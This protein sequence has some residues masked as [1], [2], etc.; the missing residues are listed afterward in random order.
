MRVGGR[1]SYIALVHEFH[2]FVPSDISKQKAHRVAQLHAQ[3]ELHDPPSISALR[4]GQVP[5]FANTG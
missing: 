5:V 4:S 1:P 3:H 2:V